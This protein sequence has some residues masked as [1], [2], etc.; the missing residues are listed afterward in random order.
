MLRQ[1]SIIFTI[2]GICLQQ[3]GITLCDISVYVF[4]LMSWIGVVGIYDILVMGLWILGRDEGGIL[5]LREV[6]WILFKGALIF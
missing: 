5:E 4:S 2:F 3:L 6:W 1:P